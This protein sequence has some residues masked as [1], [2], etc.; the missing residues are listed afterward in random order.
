MALI[1]LPGRLKNLDDGERSLVLCVEKFARSTAHTIGAAECS[2]FREDRIADRSSN[3]GAK[4]RSG[5][6]GSDWK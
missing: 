3:F 2:G 5:G 1:A 6:R 4:C